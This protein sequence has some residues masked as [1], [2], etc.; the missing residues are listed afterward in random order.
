[1]NIV[2]E[3]GDWDTWSRTI[4]RQVLS[5]QSPDFAKAQLDVTFDRRRSEFEQIKGLTNPQIRRKLLETFGDETDSA[6]VHLKAANMP[7][8]ATKVILP[9]NRVK[10]DEIFAPTFDNGERVALIRYPHAGRF[11]IPELTVNNRSREVA[12]MFGG[13]DV[14]DAIAIHP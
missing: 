12:K 4:S 5:K 2:H 1:M 6:A 7:R 10:P 14:P 13:R 8:Q 11:E 3:E 9:S